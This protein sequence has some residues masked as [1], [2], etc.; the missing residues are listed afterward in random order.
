MLQDTG[1]SHGYSFNTWSD[2]V[3]YNNEFI[4]DWLDSPQ[5][6]MYYSLQVRRNTQ[7]KDDAMVALGDEAGD[8][9]IFGFDDIDADDNDPAIDWIQNQGCVGCAE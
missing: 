8:F 1:L 5:T 6:S 4:Q 3:C 9:S 7:A 2:H